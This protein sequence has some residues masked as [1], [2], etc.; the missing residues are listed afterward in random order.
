M[1]ES[2]SFSIAGT[3]VTL[4]GNLGTTNTLEYCVDGDTMH[5]M[6]LAMAMPTGMTGP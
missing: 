6:R 2:G 5:L 1:S 3:A 4:A